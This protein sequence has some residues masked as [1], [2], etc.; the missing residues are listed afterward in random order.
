LWV[1]C[2]LVKYIKKI[3]KRKGKS[4]KSM[5]GLRLGEGEP[6]G[7]K[8]SLKGNVPLRCHKIYREKHVLWYFSWK[9]KE[10]N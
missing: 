7:C 5:T 6:K 8:K 10:D 2:I 1:N 4:G 9:K 3:I